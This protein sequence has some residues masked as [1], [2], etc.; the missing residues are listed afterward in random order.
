MEK[1]LLGNWKNFI[2]VILNNVSQGYWYFSQFQYPEKKRDKWEK[3]DEK[4]I[5]KYNVNIS[6]DQ[7]YRNKKK[8]KANYRFFRWENQAILL[9]TEGER[10]Q[11]D[12]ER[13]IKLEGKERI[14]IIVGNTEF[15]IKKINEKF[16]VKVSKKTFSEIKTDIKTK[17]EKKLINQA[18][19]VFNNF[20]NL[21]NYT[22][23][24]KQKRDIID[25]FVENCKKNF[26]KGQIKKIKEELKIKEVALRKLP[27]FINPEQR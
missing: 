21:P 7:R 23:L 22:F 13:W 3:I 5:N 15:E 8:G 18:L 27:L 17:L 9:R 6:K 26:K 10:L 25:F 2:Y 14:L 11:Q 4:I 20:N 1:Y 16:S 12:D 19:Y 24:K